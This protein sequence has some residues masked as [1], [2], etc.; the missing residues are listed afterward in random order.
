MPTVS[1]AFWN[2]QISGSSNAAGGKSLLF[3]NPHTMKFKHVANGFGLEMP[4]MST[5]QQVFDITEA[6]INRGGEVHISRCDNDVY[7]RNGGFADAVFGVKVTSENISAFNLFTKGDEMADIEFQYEGRARAREFTM[8]MGLSGGIV[9]DDISVS[10]QHGA[11]PGN[12]SLGLEAT[13]PVN[14]NGLGTGA[15]FGPYSIPWA[16]QVVSDH[17]RV[18]AWTPQDVVIP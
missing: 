7:G 8:T 2:E 14:T 13:I 4:N 3:G 11:T 17:E 10:G 5:S 15:G 1:T 6:S 9:N 16:I 18:D 12:A